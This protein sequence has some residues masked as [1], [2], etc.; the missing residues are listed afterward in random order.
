MLIT[1]LIILAWLVHKFDAFSPASANR[2]NIDRAI[3]LRKPSPSLRAIS[4]D[5]TVE[6]RKEMRTW[7]PFSLAVLKLKITE[8]A[9][10]SSLNYQSLPVPTCVRIAA[11]HSSPRRGNSIAVPGGRRFGRRSSQIVLHS[12]VSGMVGRSVIARIVVDI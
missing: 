6:G 11:I 4:E 5:D 1:T 10:T 7:N 2:G 9:W 8:P 3:I 12:T